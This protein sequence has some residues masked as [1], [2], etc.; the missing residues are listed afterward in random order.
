MRKW[1]SAL[2]AKVAMLA[3][4]AAFA[5]PAYA[6]TITFSDNTFNLAN[7]STL[8]QEFPTGAVTSISQTA[9]GN[10]G[11]A[12]Q[13]TYVTSEPFFLITVA[14]V[15]GDFSYNPS[16]A[17]GVTSI[18]VAL[19]RY[20]LPMRD[21]LDPGVGGFTLRTFVV[22]N[23]NY[24]Q[25]VQTFPGLAPG[26]SDQWVSLAATNL[27]EA[28]FQLF[29]FTNAAVDP[30]MNPDFDQA[31]T[32]GFGMRASGGGVPGD[33]T[34][35]LRADNWVVTLHTERDVPEPASA[36]LAGL[37]LLGLGWAR[38]RRKAA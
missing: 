4:A 3:V 11:L 25:A 37:G 30:T 33:N 22:Q 34:G 27:Q 7:Y 38:R 20:F 35:T 2:G 14:F 29:D 36:A 19:D 28:D 26:E 21:G 15:R 23:G 18:D 16:L 6:G 9:S 17:G 32:L 5:G 10:P 8:V 13:A 24:Y 1:I 12:A 31:F